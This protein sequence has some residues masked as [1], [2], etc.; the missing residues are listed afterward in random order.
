MK[1]TTFFMLVLCLQVAARSSGQTV[2]LSASNVKITRVLRDIQM[3]TGYTIV[4]EQELLNRVGR[5]TLSVKNA[6][7]ME[8]LK[9]AL[10]GTAVDFSLQGSIVTLK[11][12]VISEVVADIPV[13][14]LIIIYQNV[15]GKVVSTEGEVLTNVS[16]FNINTRKGTVTSE[17][18]IF[19]IEAKAGDVLVFT[20]VGFKPS[21]HKVSATNGI[22][23]EMAPQEVNMDEFVATGYQSIRKNNM[24]GSAAKVKAEDLV[25]NGTTTIEQMLQGKL[26]GVEVANTSGLIGTRQTVRVRG[27]STLFGNQ[28]PVWV[29]DGIIQEDP[30]PFQ[31]K[32][33]NQFNLE[34]SN[35]QQL[36]NFVGSSISWLNPYDI[37][38]VT[39]L[40]DAASTAIYGV[41]AAN[42]V[43]LITTKK[44]KEGRAP[45]I[46]Y[47]GGFSTENK[48]SYDKM[49]LMNSKERVDVSREIYQ[50]GLL[51]LWL[52]DRVGY[53][54]LLQQLLEDKIN[55][56]AFET[57]VKQLE[58]NNTDWFDILMQRPFNM[59]HNISVSGGGNNNTY[60]GSFGYR[61]QRG[62]A[63]GNGQESYQGSINFNSMIN[64]RLTF[65]AKVAGEYTITNGFYSVDPYSYAATTTR[66]LSAYEPGGALSYYRRGV[67]Q[68]NIINEL[69]NTGN[70]NYKTSLNSNIN[71]KYRLG[72]GFS[73]E[74]VFGA[75][76]SNVNSE[77]YASERSYNIAPIRGYNYGAYLPSELEYKKSRLPIGGMLS[78]SGERNFNYTWRNSLNFVRSIKN[79]HTLNGLIG[80]ELR[81]NQYDGNAQTVYGYLPDRGKTISM[82]P[83]THLDG[84]GVNPIQNSLYSTHF[85]NTLTDRKA[86]YFS[87]F[88]SGT[89][90]Y[91]N[92]YS[93]S[94]S[95]RGDASNRFGQDVRTRFKPI[96]SLGG[97]W[98]VA[99]EAFFSKT[100]WMNDLSI[101]ASYGFQGNVAEGYGPD[102]IAYVPVGGD[103]VSLLTG[104]ALLKIKS[105]PYANL[106][107]EK[108]QTVNLGF[109]MSLFRGQVGLVVDY[110]NKRSKDLIVMMD[111]PYENGVLQM[112]MNGGTL[113]NSGIDIAI[114]LTPV[115]TENVTWSL[116]VSAGKNFNKLT[117]RLQQN[118]TWDV[119]RSGS[120]YVQ[121]YPVSS[122]W[123]FDYTGPDAR[124]GVPT[125]HIPTA[126]ENPNATYD[127]TAFMKYAGKLNPDFTGGFNT[128]LRYKTLTFS[129][130]AY[131]S[132]G[133]DKILAPLYGSDMIN[134]TPNEYN[135]L[136]ADLV[137]RWR[138]PGDVT[139]IPGLP[140]AGVPQLNIPSGNNS[141]GTLLQ[142]GA[143]SPYTLFNYS[144]ARVVNASY[145]RINNIMLS[146][147]LPGA[148]AKR[149]S[150]KTATLSYAMGNVHVFASKDFK[151]VDPEVASGSQPLSQTHSFNIAI[152]F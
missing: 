68:Y 57:G 52:L 146:Y 97:R 30:L 74:S 66:V 100:S 61:S 8:V 27:V 49:N 124:T 131:L 4:A 88:A 7:V 144:T 106:R 94:A 85:A 58:V 101:R 130:N 98:N 1:L 87:Y 21:Q 22:Y 151:G 135:N 136:S 109:D 142:A 25:I 120:Y 125:F 123:V 16:V 17:K 62:Q 53:Q 137:R 141:Y 140:W 80:M 90:S 113:Y 67:L 86:N 18:G 10:S 31:A 81:S 12:K 99:N 24:T 72:K 129:T 47:S 33:L 43:I 45:T 111:V 42:G 19:S 107:W 20:Y 95:L 117:S 36:R 70:D 76:F 41:K 26:A 56:T 147:T 63:K 77:A 148:I 133:A 105:L 93:L 119:A 59:S 64:S 37:D 65:S 126:A 108:T 127:A 143:A 92:R 38:E 89:Y 84:G 9:L 145:L 40:K 39:V 112:P 55:Y 152:A 118:P 114:N 134:S 82:P 2:T 48:L 60:Y 51:S 34:P 128:S 28:E 110:Y 13:P 138:Q 115:K 6:S 116:G 150:A 104:E 132:L 11:K 83:I 44:G 5:V 69:N 139:D 15:T 50:R 73:F 3:Q 149:L 32:E 122:F 46:N 23:I 79:K 75:N 121:G 91:S 71:V 29:V 103:A 78:S 35:S 54:G 102:L 96:W 14:G